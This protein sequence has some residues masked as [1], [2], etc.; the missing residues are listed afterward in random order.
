VLVQ[1]KN[2]DDSPLDKKFDQATILYSERT[3]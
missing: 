3:F 1:L 2:P